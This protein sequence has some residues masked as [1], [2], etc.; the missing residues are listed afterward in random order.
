MYKNSKI[1][2]PF[3]NTIKQYYV[4]QPKNYNQIAETDNKICIIAIVLDQ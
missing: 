2:I 3:C 1:N 4:Y